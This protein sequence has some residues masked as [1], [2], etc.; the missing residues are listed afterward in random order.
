MDANDPSEPPA[1]PPAC[2]VH[3]SPAVVSNDVTAGTNEPTRRERTNTSNDDTKNTND[4]GSGLVLSTDD[5]DPISCRAIS[6]AAVESIAT[7]KEVT[8]PTLPSP[9]ATYD[10]ESDDEEDDPWDREGWVPRTESGEQKSPNTIRNELQRYID[11]CKADGSATT[12]TSIAQRLG[13]NLISFSRF[14]NPRHYANQWSATRSGT[15]LAGA[16][17]LARLERE[18]EHRE[19]RIGGKSIGAVDR[20]EAT[21]GG[22]RKSTNSVDDDAIGPTKKARTDVAVDGGFGRNADAPPPRRERR[23]DER[24]RKAQELIRGVQAV[25]GANTTVIYDTCPEVVEGIKSFLR[26]EGVTK[27]MLLRAMGNVNDNSMRKFFNG[28]DQDQRANVSYRAGYAFLE[29]LRLYE[30][31]PKSE[32]RLRN[33]AEN[34]DG[35]S[36]VKERSKDIF[37]GLPIWKLAPHAEHLRKQ[38][39]KMRFE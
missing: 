32:A 31:R 15:Y 2:A 38:W 7:T 19:R 9:T 10:V 17:L 23:V 13:I 1:S 35:F 22:K 11:Q 18:G 27:K 25:E 8:A 24:T 4:D 3:A 30:G 33:E 28:K 26:R 14:M 12:K 20:G 5:Y 34:P 16:R 6:F 39:D 36:I 21:G 29:K 37:T